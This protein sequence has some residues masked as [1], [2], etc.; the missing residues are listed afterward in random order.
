M[1]PGMM[2][3]RGRRSQTR[4]ATQ[5]MKFTHRRLPETARGDI[6]RTFGHAEAAQSAV[7]YIVQNE[8]SDFVLLGHSYG[9]FIISK[10]AEALPDR[11][12]RLVYWN[13][14]VLMDA[15]SIES[16]SPPPYKEMMDSIVASGAYA[17]GGVKLPFPSG[18]R[19][20]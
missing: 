15:E 3:P 14:F 12:R 9:G 1:A 2:V 10:M 6:D 13:A 17:P 18:E 11:I 20:S 16:V 8:L 5:G 7:D 19:H 4:Y